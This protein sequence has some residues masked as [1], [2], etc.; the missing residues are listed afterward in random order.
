MAGAVI[1]AIDPGNT[2]SGYALI[3]EKTCR[4]IYVGKLPNL[5]ILDLIEHETYRHLRVE[6][7]ASYGMAVGKEV[8]E[9]CVWIGRFLQQFENNYEFT[10]SI[11][12]V[13]RKDVK[14]HHCYSA[15][16]KDAN[17]IQALID[18]FASGEPNRGKGTKANPGWFYG[19][20]A[21]IWQAYALAVY[22]NDRL[23]SSDVEG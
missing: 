7:I 2:H 12:L 17:I 3:E 4:P 8:F 19:F 13:Y 15:K 20:S 18:R 10:A 11:A 22:A 14:L 6:M 5:E 16:A 1:L 9:T 21:D 23:E